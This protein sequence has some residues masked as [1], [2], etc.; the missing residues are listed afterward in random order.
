MTQPIDYP[1]FATD[2]NYTNGPNVGTPTKV[3]PSAG[4][5]AEGNISGTAPS[6]QKANWWQSLVG[7]WIRYFS[8]EKVPEIEASIVDLRLNLQLSNWMQH[9]GVTGDDVY[10][11]IIWSPI[12]NLYVAVGGN[13]GGDR[14]TVTSP[15]GVIWTEQ[16]E[17]TGTSG[18]WS[19]IARF[20]GT[21]V[22]AGTGGAIDSG[23]A[24]SWTART[25]AGGYAGIFRGA[26]HCS[27]LLLFVLVGSG[28]AIQTSPN[29]TTWTARTADG[30]YSDDFHCVAVDN[31]SPMFVI[32]GENGEIQT[33]PNGTTWTARTADGSYSGTFYG[34]A[35]T[36][37]LF[38][39]VGS[40]GE[41]QTS[42]DGVTWTAR[43][44][45]ESFSGQF[46]SVFWSAEAGCLIA[47]GD[48]EIQTSLDGITWTRRV[49][50]AG[51]TGSLNAGTFVKDICLLVGSD[52]SGS[53]QAVA[54]ASLRAAL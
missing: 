17:G 33:S 14:A 19:C 3:T 5:L 31:D 22:V 8:E 6:A 46:T 51:F 16:S 44:A 2:A 34:A 49:A 26:G 9:D 18:D 27:S 20:G 37:S 30:S 7:L 13:N 29:G 42:P 43:A 23:S 36:G 1:D 39:L 35:W 10:N 45:D 38:V 48:G 50:P 28:G 47:V 53:A 15:D 54:L 24:T 32:A 25:A 41:I 21:L 52:T 40:T 12:D 4:E 11:A